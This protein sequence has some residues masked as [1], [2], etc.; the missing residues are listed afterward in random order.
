[1]RSIWR[2]NRGTSGTGHLR[3]SG[4]RDLKLAID[5]IPDLIG[6][7]TPAKLGDRASAQRGPAPS[8][9]ERGSAAHLGGSIEKSSARA[10]APDLLEQNFWG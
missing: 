8:Y 6:R 7:R 3:L 10:I 1:M 4:Y 5:N 2:N 9:L